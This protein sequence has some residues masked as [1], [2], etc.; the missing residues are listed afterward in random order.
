MASKPE[1][2]YNLM[3]LWRIARHNLPAVENVYIEHVNGLQKHRGKMDVA[4][5]GPCH[6]EW[7]ITATIL[8]QIMRSTSF[9]FQN[10]SNGLIE[11]I[12]AFQYVDG[13]NAKGLT[14][15]GKG[16]QEEIEN[17]KDE[18]EGPAVVERDEYKLKDTPDPNRFTPG[19]VHNVDKLEPVERT[20]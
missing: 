7:T 20:R 3:S 2:S 15:A 18:V 1:L 6:T 14:E 11:A 12:N 4:T 13:D 19:P 10:V 5:Y 9:S 8:E 16:L 17:Y